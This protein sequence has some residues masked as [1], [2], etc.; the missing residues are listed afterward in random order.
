LKAFLKNKKK[1]MAMG[2]P[3][4][5]WHFDPFF[6][7]TLVLGV[8]NFFSKNLDGRVSN[9]G[10]YEGPKFQSILIIIIIIMVI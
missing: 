9:F 2:I 3:I 5:L 7:F 8:L 4:C 1:F 6:K 10:C